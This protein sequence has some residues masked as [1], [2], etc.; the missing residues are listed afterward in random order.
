MERD[1]AQSDAS[2]A[3]RIE[4][5]TTL[6]TLTGAV[7]FTKI[8]KS[9]ALHDAEIS[10]HSERVCRFFLPQQPGCDTDVSPN[11]NRAVTR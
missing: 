5:L 4:L 8:L 3:I 1:K 6:S 10:Q 2:H 7:E 9:H 11:M